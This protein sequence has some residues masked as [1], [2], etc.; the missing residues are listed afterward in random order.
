MVKNRVKVRRVTR[1]FTQ[2]K[3]SHVK[4][5]ISD[6]PDGRLRAIN[7]RQMTCVI[8]IR[9]KKRRWI[10]WCVFAGIDMYRTG[11][12]RNFLQRNIYRPKP[13]PIRSY[14]P[15]RIWMCCHTWKTDIW[16]RRK[17]RFDFFRLSQIFRRK[18]ADFRLSRRAIFD[19]TD[20]RRVTCVICI[21][22]KKRRWID[23]CM[24]DRIDMYRSRDIN[25]S[26]Q[27]NIHPE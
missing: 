18:I 20:C 25:N 14:R 8:C 24:F 12:K 1:N 22:C 9:C 2:K 17:T 5:Q 23:W 26:F 19:A 16:Q 6:Y 11:D 10:D 15:L 4:S 13:F 7:C 27:C 21:R 3:C